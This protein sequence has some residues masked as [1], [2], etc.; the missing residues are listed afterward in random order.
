MGN[1]TALPALDV[2]P[3]ATP[4]N[5]LAEFGQVAAIQSH[6]QQQQI[7]QQEI[8]K[9]QQALTDQQAVTKAM[10]E[11][12]PSTGDYNALTQSALK[13]GA[14]STAAT[15][16]QQHGLQVTQ[17]AATLDETKRKAFAE[18]RKAL[19]DDLQPLTDP[20][21]VPD[22]QLQSEALNHITRQV[23]A[24]NLSMP[25]AQPLIAGIQQTNDPTTLRNLIMQKAK[26]DLGMAGIMAQKKTEAETTE[27]TEKGAQAKAGATKENLIPFPELGIIHHVDTGVNE[28]VS[29][30]TMTPGMMESKYLTLQQQ[31]NEGKP[32][33]ADDQAFVKGYEK[34]KTLVP[35]ANFNLQN[36]IPPGA[37]GQPSAIAKG[38]A[39]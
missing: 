7:Q 36:A 2:R 21:I 18:K 3:P 33:N 5:A 39:D 1:L 25:E 22:D 20:E 31:K 19:A 32:L 10:N 13:Y 23:Q 8:Q 38:L 6:L 9:N 15:A 24:G 4:P 27:A 17:L 16:L 26:T 12:D 35:T 14:S 34:M 11:W 29:G 37:N 28:P 30:N